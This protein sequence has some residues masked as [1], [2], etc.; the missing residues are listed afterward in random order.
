MIIMGMI[1]NT[2][3]MKPTLDE[4][5]SLNQ[6]IDQ[7]THNL[8]F[9][10]S[11]NYEIVFANPNL[12]SILCYK[13]EGFLGT[14]FFQHVHTDDCERVKAEFD[15]TF[16]IFSKLIRL[17]NY[18]LND[19]NVFKLAAKDQIKTFLQNY[20]KSLRT[21][22]AIRPIMFRVKRKNGKWCWLESSG[23]PFVAEHGE[24]MITISARDVTGSIKLQKL[25]K[26]NLRKLNKKYRY[27]TIVRTVTQYVHKSIN[28][29]E[30]FENAVDAI[31][32][33]VLGAKYVFRFI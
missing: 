12:K 27:E 16:R 9:V 11:I 19:G 13:V 18:E 5:L 20:S 15:N 17:D 25:L 14:N 4:P 28:I 1:E 30:V 24:I 29:R 32:N 3:I 21:L 26:M 8:V 23:I 10:L 7:N 31:H 2:K 33:N 6:N 22:S